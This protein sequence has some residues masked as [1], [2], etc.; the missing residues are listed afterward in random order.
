MEIQEADIQ[1]LVCP[2]NVR[3]ALLSYASCLA[4]TLGDDIVAAYVCGSIVRGCYQPITSD[5]DV[6]VVVKDNPAA[7]LPTSMLLVQRYGRLPVDAVVVTESELRADVFPTPI[8]FQVKPG[9]DEVV[10]PAPGGSRDFLLS[11]QDAREAGIAFVGPPAGALMNPVPWPLLAQSLD[12]LFPNIV[13]QFKNPVLTLCRVA[14]A[15]ANHELCSKEQAGDWACEALG[16]QWFIMIRTAL[17]EYACGNSF[18]T[19]PR[20]IIRSFEAYC[21]DYIDNLR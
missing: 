16:A 17:T 19:T 12:S 9:M 10:Q 3:V 7:N 18:S 5:V 15:W 21:A 4:A 13:L 8:Q 2:D 1:S 6:L 20:D 14:Y 11:R